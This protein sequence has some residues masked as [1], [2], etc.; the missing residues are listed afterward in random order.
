MWSIKTPLIQSGA[1]IR[2]ATIRNV[3][4]YGHNQFSHA[5]YYTLMAAITE[6][7]YI[8]IRHAC[9]H[10]LSLYFDPLYGHPCVTDNFPRHS[11]FISYFSSH[12]LC[13][14]YHVAP[15]I[16]WIHFMIFTAHFLGAH[17]IMAHMLLA[18]LPRRLRPIQLFNFQECHCFILSR[19]ISRWFLNF[20]SF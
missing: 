19:I 16:A 7:P 3:P 9:E 20:V 17:I 4:W 15:D 13:C 10:T 1:T 5:I 11:L 12:C 8:Q 2:S 6:C 18:P 14:N